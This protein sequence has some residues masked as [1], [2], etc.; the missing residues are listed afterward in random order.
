MVTLGIAQNEM[1]RRGQIAEALIAAEQPELLDL[2]LTYQNEAI[3]ARKFLDSSLG[4]LTADAKILEVGGGI[5]AL[6][7]QLASEGFTVTT[8]EP[9]GAGFGGIPFIM[10]IFTKIA[11]N[12][13][14]DFHLITSPIEDCKF[15]HKFDFVFSIN[16]MEHL[17]N[18]YSVLIQLVDVLN[19]SGKYRFFCPNY[20]FPYEPHFGK[21]LYFRKNNAFYLQESRARSLIVADEEVLGLYRSL[22]FITLKSLT[23]FSHLNRVQIKSNRKAF[24]NLLERVIYDQ[25]LSKRHRA[26]AM[27]VRLLR[28]FK[29]HYIAKLIPTNYQPIMDIEASRFKI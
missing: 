16:V 17:K 22:N 29:M 13:S 10:E 3:A 28:T 20:D 6:A 18:P 14:L 9:V 27:F 8:V 2:Y 21:W 26:L 12:E 19:N 15:V 23:K 1:K 11:R 25:K 7:V 5:L 24:H 4:E